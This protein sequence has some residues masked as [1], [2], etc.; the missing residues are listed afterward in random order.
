MLVFVVH[1]IEN[2]LS[3]EVQII[4]FKNELYS[5]LNDEYKILNVLYNS[6]FTYSII[7]IQFLHDAK[8]V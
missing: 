5:W 3:V 1:L 7:L 6:Y 2:R 4:Q 8:I